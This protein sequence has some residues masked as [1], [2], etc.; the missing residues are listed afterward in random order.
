MKREQLYNLTAEAEMAE[1]DLDG[2]FIEHIRDF[3][4]Q[5]F[6]ECEIRGELLTDEEVVDIIV[7][8]TYDLLR[9]T[10]DYDGQ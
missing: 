4:E 6:L 8:A 9:H 5:I 1:D 2:N 10:K 7:V 3:V